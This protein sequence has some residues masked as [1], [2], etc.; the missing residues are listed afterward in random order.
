MYHLKD[1]IAVDVRRDE[2]AAMSR[3]DF[4]DCL[5]WLWSEFRAPAT[6]SAHQT[7]TV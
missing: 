2:Y 5:S 4:H 7:Q 3:D 6:S 1:P